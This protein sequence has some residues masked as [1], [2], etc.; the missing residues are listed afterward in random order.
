[1]LTW[2]EPADKVYICYRCLTVNKKQEL[3]ND[4]KNRLLRVCKN[5]NCKTFMKGN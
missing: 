2:K 5:C 1:M 3:R 4:K